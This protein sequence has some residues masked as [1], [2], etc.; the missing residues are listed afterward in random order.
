MNSTE[1]H[2]KNMVCGRCIKVVTEVLHSLDFSVQSIDL[3]RAVVEKRGN[4]NRSL[5]AMELQKDGF[6][7]ISDEM[8][9]LITQIKTEIIQLIHAPVHNASNVNLS[10]FLEKSLGKKYTTLSTIFSKMEGR[11]IEKF[12]IQQRIER[13]KELLVYGEKTISEIAW[14]LGYSSSQYLSNQFKAETGLTASEFRKLIIKPRKH[15]DSI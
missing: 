13:V 15:L 7:L 5:I 11:T 4:I 3:G 10:T 2:I 8:T 1:L 9:R 6:E 14:E 12:A